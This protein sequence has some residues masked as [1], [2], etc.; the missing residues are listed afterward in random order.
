M[1]TRFPN[2]AYDLDIVEI[3]R[4]GRL[5]WCLPTQVRSVGIAASVQLTHSDTILIADPIRSDPIRHVVWKSTARVTWSG[6]L[7][8]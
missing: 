8:R 2:R 7:E 1:K 3:D 6:S 5:L 4:Q